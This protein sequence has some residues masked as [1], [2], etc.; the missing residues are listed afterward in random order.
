[1]CQTEEEEDNIW[2]E[3]VRRLQKALANKMVK[4]QGGI[5][6]EGSLKFTGM[7]A[8]PKYRERKKRRKLGRLL[9]HQQEIRRK[10]F[11][12]TK[13]EMSSKR[14]KRI[15]G[16]QSVPA[17]R[18][19][20]HEA[21]ACNIK[22]LSK[23]L[24]DMKQ[25]RAEA[26]ILKWKTRMREGIKDVSRWLKGK[27]T[28]Q[29]APVITHKRRKA[30]NMV[31]AAEMI[32]E[33]WLE[34]WAH[35]RRPG[36]ETVWRHAI[37]LIVQEYSEVMKE[38]EALGEWPEPTLEEMC[39]IFRTAQGAASSDGWSSKELNALPTTVIECF[40]A[41]TARWLRKGRVPAPIKEV[42]QVNLPK[43]AQIKKDNT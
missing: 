21:L 1:L 13:R 11:E 30:Q 5:I 42:R 20:Y 14:N 37:E 28:M 12:E 16:R 38:I 9:G 18:K 34:T 35:Q 17:T 25:Q 8:Y 43:V 33:H 31:E 6:A 41:L 27:T 32:K 2:S 4:G 36:V 22:H 3:D 15:W 7:D 24:E 29:S 10:N 26:N 19:E 23:E 39:K 40:L